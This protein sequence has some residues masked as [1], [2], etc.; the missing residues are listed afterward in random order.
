MDR[1]A[2]L[3]ILEL[4]ADA[5]TAQIEQRFELLV[6]R[7]R[8]ATDPKTLA[9]MHAS[10]Q[11]YEFL[12]AASRPVPVLKPSSQKMI[13]GKTRADWANRWHYDKWIW[14]G[15]V[16]VVAFVAYLGW[17]MITNRPADFKVVVIGDFM[18]K[19]Q[20]VWTDD[21]S[22]AFQQ[23]V[24]KVLAPA[25]PDVDEVDF[26]W[27][28]IS[29]NKNGTIAPTQDAA[30]QQN[31]L[32]KVVARLGA[33]DLDVL[34]FDEGAYT[35]YASQATFVDLTPLLIQLKAAL[36]TA[37]FAKIKPLQTVPAGESGVVSGL[38]ITE[39]TGIETFG[40]ASE[41]T[42]LTIGPR[43]Q[44]PELAIE[45]LYGWLSSSTN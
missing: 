30:T 1:Q 45:W 38:D 12:K 25:H 16:A 41:S 29:F 15:I 43:C 19:D 22:V 8:H 21:V 2:A 36:P 18:L 20:D 35:S 13:F 28:P 39:L 6:R 14:L 17:T 27:M 42:I 40:L 33:D 32:I 11:A 31:M 34:I 23:S 10:T 3:S 9:E 26:E 24:I 4:P 44:Q 5:T 7:Y 37:Q